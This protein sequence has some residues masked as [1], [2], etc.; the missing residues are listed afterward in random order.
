MFCEPEQGRGAPPPAVQ[1]AAWPRSCRTKC[2]R[3][4]GGI[5]RRKLLSKARREA[6]F[7]PKKKHNMSMRGATPH[8]HI[9]FFWEEK[10]ESNDAPKSRKGCHKT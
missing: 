9:I 3:T 6:T 5:N 4:Y 10:N 1:A 7:S 2:D 8:T